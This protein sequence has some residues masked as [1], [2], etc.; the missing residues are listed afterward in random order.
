[1]ASHARRALADSGLFQHGRW[2]L[3][4]VQM[5]LGPPS[6]LGDAVMRW[7]LGHQRQAACVGLQPIGDLFLCVDVDHH[8]TREMLGNRLHQL[9]PRTRGQHARRVRKVANI[10]LLVVRRESGDRHVD[11]GLGDTDQQRDCQ[12]CPLFDAFHECNS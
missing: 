1:M 2:N 12:G 6:R 10:A 5:D 11:L 7:L 8:L 4:V 9:F 3:G